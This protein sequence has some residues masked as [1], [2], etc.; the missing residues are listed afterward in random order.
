MTTPETVLGLLAEPARLRVLSAVALGAGSPSEVR[1]A[2]GTSPKETAV[3]LRRLTDGGMVEETD[4]GLRVAEPDFFREL[5]RAAR[6]GQPTE[7]GGTG[8]DALLRTFVR[9]GRLRAVPSRFER[10]RVVLRHMVRGSFR[11]GVRYTE[12]QVDETLKTWCEGST[13]DHVTIRRH[14][15]DLCLLSREDGGPYWLREDAPAGT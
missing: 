15:I 14:L 1:E 13:T 11:P 5:T 7:G 12:K 10:R 4:A 3:A 6:G 2:A 9:D 8:A